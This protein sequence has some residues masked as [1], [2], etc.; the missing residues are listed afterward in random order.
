MSLCFTNSKSCSS[1]SL[2]RLPN[3]NNAFK[4]CHHFHRS[5][6]MMSHKKFCIKLN[7]CAL[8]GASLATLLLCKYKTV[9]YC[10]KKLQVMIALCI[11]NR[12]TTVCFLIVLRAL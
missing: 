6:Q 2:N 5:A 10:K 11:R 4:V 3:L 12:A 9:Q 1:L 8:F 7:Q